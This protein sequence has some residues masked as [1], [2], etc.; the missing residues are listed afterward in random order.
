MLE[1]AS[2]AFLVEA[3]HAPSPG[4]PTLCYPLIGRTARDENWLEEGIL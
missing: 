3:G 4:R 1:H 2:N